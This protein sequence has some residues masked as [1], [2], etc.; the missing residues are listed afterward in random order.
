LVAQARAEGM[1]LVTTDSAV[2]QYK[3]SVM[4]V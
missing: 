1:V 2:A 4:A 3:E